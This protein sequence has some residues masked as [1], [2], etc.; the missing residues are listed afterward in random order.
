[1]AGKSDIESFA[2]VGGAAALGLYLAG[3]LVVNAYLF[4][5][6]VTDF[7]PLNPRFV[8]TGAVVLFLAAVAFVLFVTAFSAVEGGVR[9]ALLRPALVS[10][11]LAAYV[12]LLLQSGRLQ[13]PVEAL[14]QAGLLYASD[15]AFGL[16]AFSIWV[17]AAPHRP[18]A[19]VLW[20]KKVIEPTFAKVN[21]RFDWA[22][23]ILLILLVPIV[24]GLCMTAHGLYAYPEIPPQFGGARPTAA[25]VLLEGALADQLGDA[26]GRA[27]V[28][29][30]FESEDAFVAELESG[31]VI[32]LS[33]D[34][35]AAVE[36]GVRPE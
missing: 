19:G 28:R 13:G 7:S 17:T 5:L 26:S 33:K 14:W 21:K 35:I 20:N 4:G 32:R 31:R 9:K 15:I 22:G 30:L 8:Y 23:R 3:L 25:V 10:L 12:A 18:E 24:F 34:T 2:R 36:L 29:L 27:E 16:T 1:M 6:G 11:P